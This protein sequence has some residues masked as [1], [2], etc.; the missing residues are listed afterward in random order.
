L[1]GK[2]RTE[3]L[4]RSL[5]LG[6]RIALALTLLALI[7]FWYVGPLLLELWVGPVD[8]G[9]TLLRLGLILNVA[10]P[11][12]VA[13]YMMLLGCGDFRGL[14]LAGI[15]G[16]LLNVSVAVVLTGTVGI[17]GPL[18]GTIAGTVAIVI[19]IVPRATR[20]VDRSPRIWWRE[21]ALPPIV[22][23]FPLIPLALCLEV[24]HV[25]HPVVVVL[26]TVVGVATYAASAFMV[27]FTQE[28]RANARR[29]ALTWLDQLLMLSRAWRHRHA[30]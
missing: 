1:H 16:T 10:W 11:G 2:A 5:L 25:E 3:E 26:A 29:L 20:V 19:L 14:A 6:T 8:Q 27:A 12:S 22:A 9:A 17:V 4:N 7:A 28:E 23:L 15:A 18:L 13:L 21:A 30:Q 24:A